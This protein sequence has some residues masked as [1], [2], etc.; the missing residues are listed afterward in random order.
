MHPRLLIAAVLV[1][2]GSI[3]RWTVIPTRN[4]SSTGIRRRA[5]GL[6]HRWPD[7]RPW[8]AG[9]VLPLMRRF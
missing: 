1:V 3:Q 7:R 9:A 8:R 4:A 5:R 6:G 2:L